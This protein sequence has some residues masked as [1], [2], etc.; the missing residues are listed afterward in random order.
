MMRIDVERQPSVRARRAFTLIELLVVISIIVLLIGLLL[1]ALSEARCTA[2]NAIE[3]SNMRQLSTATLGYASDFSDR[4]PSFTWKPGVAYD[5]RS[6]ESYPAE[7]QSVDATANQATEIMRFRSSR[8]D[9]TVPASWIPH[10]LYSHLVIND[11]LGQRLPEPMVVSPNDEFRL[12][13]Q[14][15]VSQDPAL[16]DAEAEARTN[17]SGNDAKRWT[18]SSSYQI[19]PAA[20]SPDSGDKAIEQGSAHFNYFIPG[21]TPFGDRKLSS[22]TFPG[23]K[24]LWYDG[25]QRRCGGKEGNFYGYQG[26]QVV[27]ASFD[28]AARFL[29]T[30]CEAAGSLPNVNPGFRPQDPTSPFPT[31]MQYQPA[32]YEPPAQVGSSNIVNGWY[33]WTRGGLAGM[34]FGGSEVNTGQ[35]FTR[36][37]RSP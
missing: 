17:S 18:Y 12:T 23:Q 10:I 9:L 21:S 1:P 16:A 7:S 4:I 15:L 2:K 28:G 8:D 31:Q 37:C 36:P 29:T 30:R 11:Y 24:V 22:V 3:F 20:F 35:A 34:D 32:D 25:K 5:G 6:G 27:M 33:R 13:L 14:R 26:S 19:V